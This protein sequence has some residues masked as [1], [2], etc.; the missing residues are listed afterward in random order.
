MKKIII[1]LLKKS[2]SKEGIDISEKNIEKILEIPRLIEMGDYAFPCFF[3]SEKLKKDPHE[4]ALDIRKNVGPLPSEIED[5]QTSGAYINFFINRKKIA[6]NLIREV[7]I[8]KEKFGKT[9]LGKG[10]RTMVEFVSPN[11]NKPLHL[12]HLRN[13]SIGESISRILEFNGEKV[14]RANLNND[15]GVHIC[16]SMLAYQK[17]GKNKKPTKKIK[18]DH[19]VGEFYVKFNE[20]AKKNKKL[21]QEVQE[22]VSYTHLTLPTN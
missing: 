21:E 11:T 1:K 2:L 7:L 10:Q 14:I 4:I 9:K 8:K 6:Y 16:K 5:V 18:P 13:M 19:F 3:L 22:P 20:M 17:Y 15:R 12:G